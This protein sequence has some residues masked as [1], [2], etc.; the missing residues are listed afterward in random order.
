MMHLN[1]SQPSAPALVT[2]RRSCHRIAV[3]CVAA[4]V[5]GLPV[6]V[7]A[8]TPNPK[9]IVTAFYEMAFV[10]GQAREAILKYISP[11]TYIQHNP[12]VP[13]GRD[14]ALAVLPDIMAKTGMRAEIKR[15]IA[16]G[17]LVVVHSRAAVPGRPEVPALA[18][19]DIFRVKEGLIVEHWDVI[20]EVPKSA[21][22][23][24]T[25]F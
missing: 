22:N 15:V 20:Q 1:P 3:A 13:D 12:M 6:P 2:A 4:W 14:A 18:V 16:E 8:Q 24:N 21:A 11:S 9:E 19:V 10:K 5:L 17:D 7:L 25:M 23:A